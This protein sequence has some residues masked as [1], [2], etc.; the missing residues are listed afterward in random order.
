MDSTTKAKIGSPQLI[1]GLC[2]QGMDFTPGQI[3]QMLRIEAGG[4]EMF[5]R[6]SLTE[7]FEQHLLQPSDTH[8]LQLLIDLCD[9]LDE[10]LVRRLA[11]TVCGFAGSKRKCGSILNL[12]CDDMNSQDALNFVDD[13]ISHCKLPFASFPVILLYLFVNWVSALNTC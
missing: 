13:I 3:I 11:A 9:S 1:A 6:K 12:F 4:L 8:T 7:A 2:Q 5:I 10:A